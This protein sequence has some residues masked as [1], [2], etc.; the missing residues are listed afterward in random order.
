M[1]KYF[2]LGAGL[3]FVAVLLLLL[4]AAAPAPIQRNLF[5]TNVAGKPL[6]GSIIFSNGNHT[7]KGGILAVGDGVLN[8]TQLRFDVGSYVSDYTGSETWN[9]KTAA[10]GGADAATVARIADVNAATNAPVIKL[11]NQIQTIDPVGN[12]IGTNGF[13]GRWMSTNDIYAT[14]QTTDATT[15]TAFSFV[16]RNNSVVRVHI[17]AVAWNSTSAATYGRLACFKNNGGT[18]TQ[19]GATASLL[20]VE[21]D[22][23]YDCLPDIS[24][25]SVR[26]RVTGNTG[27]TVNWKI[28]VTLRYSE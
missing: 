15:V 8:Q 16:P 25:T 23:A 26:V 22:A 12:V 24:G 2:A 1:K 17:E 10:A 18:V 28:Y 5:T 9:F 13:D 20:V 3:S 21:E 4:G 7:F 14:I 19:V 6:I 27:R 11:P